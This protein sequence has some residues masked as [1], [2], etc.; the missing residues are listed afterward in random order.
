MQPNELETKEPLVGKDNDNQAA[1]NLL[2]CVHDCTVAPGQNSNA[3]ATGIGGMF[4]KSD[5]DEKALDDWYEKNL[6]IHLFAKH[7]GA[8]SGFA[9]LRWSDDKGAD[10][11]VTFWEPLSPAKA[12]EAFAPSK[13]DYMVN[14]RVDNL[15]KV[16]ERLKN[17]NETIVQEPKPS[18][19][20]GKS[21]FV[22]DP[23]G[24]KIELW[25]PEQISSTEDNTTGKV[26]E[27]GGVSF[28]VRG[29]MTALE[30]WYENSLGI[31]PQQTADHRRAIFNHS[32]DKA[33]DGGV[34]AWDARE[35]TTEWFGPGNADFMIDYRVDNI[36]EIYERLK[37]TNPEAIVEG[38]QCWSNG[39]FLWVMDP[40]NHKVELWEPHRNLECPK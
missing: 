29:D 27:V 34:T 37:K 2:D 31:H 22:M 40:E 1:Q 11:G 7:Q 36:D 9:I 17:N 8:E 28:E 32:D 13:F 30:N 35:K 21:L 16:F 23:A 33:D 3:R 4:F 24:H 10:G 26:T 25:E 15:E 38:P 6:G 18:D 19:K 12:S 5:A 20:G 14:Y 39:K